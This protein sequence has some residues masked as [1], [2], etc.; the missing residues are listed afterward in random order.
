MG[1]RQENALKLFSDKLLAQLIPDGSTGFVMR[2]LKAIV[3]QSEAIDVWP[4]TKPLS[5][6]G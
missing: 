1:S 5:A 6:S 3:N 2:L 4:R